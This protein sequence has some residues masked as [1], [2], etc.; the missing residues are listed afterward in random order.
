MTMAE[1]EYSKPYYRGGKASGCSQNG[2]MN[3]C[4]GCNEPIEDRFLMKVVDEAWHESCLQCCICRTPLSRSCFSKDRKLYCRNDY[5]KVFG[6]KCSGCRKTIPANELVMRAL[7]NVYHLH[8]FVCAMCGH[9]LEKGQEFALKDNKLYCKMDYA[10]LPKQSSRKSRINNN[11]NDSSKT[12][13]QQENVSNNGISCDK[14]SSKEGIKTENTDS[15]DSSVHDDEDGD[16][17]KG[18]KRPRTILTSQQ[19]KVFK[20][21]F[22]ISSKPCRKVREELS[23]ETGLSVRVVQVWFQNQRAKI[24]KLARRNNPDSDGTSSCRVSNR[25][26]SLK[27]TKDGKGSSP[28]EKRR[29]DRDLMDL[30]PDLSPSHI[31]VSHSPYGMIP[32]QFQ[33]NISNHMGS[34]IPP[35]YSYQHQPPLN[36]MDTGDMSVDQHAMQALEDCMMPQ[37]QYPPTD[38]GGYPPATSHN[39]QNHLEL[40]HDMINSF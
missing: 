11:D 39:G 9:V 29:G 21:A 28:R 38:M 6:T 40:M 1:N 27:K 7:G 13:R 25:Q 26:R 24:K 23:R 34:M 35:G 14:E 33:Q 5:E 8:C 3:I 37:H 17:K 36:H 15:D 32:S 20:S 31:P 2:R 19:R 18:P 30:P 22:E 10:K 4:T 12:I 16:D